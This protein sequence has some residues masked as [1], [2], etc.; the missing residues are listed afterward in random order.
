MIR[1]KKTQEKILKEINS[2]LARVDKCDEMSYP[3]ISPY[4]GEITQENLVKYS[5]IIQEWET[6]VKKLDTELINL[7]TPLPEESDKWFW[8]E[9]ENLKRTYWLYELKLKAEK[10]LRF[11]KYG[12]MAILTYNKRRITIN[13]RQDPTSATRYWVGKKYQGKDIGIDISEAYGCLMFSILPHQYNYQPFGGINSSRMTMKTAIKWADEK[14]LWKSKYEK[15]VWLI[16]YA[17]HIGWDKLRD[18]RLWLI[19]RWDVHKMNKNISSYL[20]CK[21]FDI[22]HFEECAESEGLDHYH[23]E[24]RNPLDF[25]DPMG[26]LADYE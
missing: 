8:L 10:R 18:L 2:Y 16:N 23:G 17:R 24:M 22:R 6:E 3:F 15:I 26:C 13:Q 21:G 1:Y 11:A 20:H 19:W 7:T 12:S 4:T 25:Q 14:A 5:D 9:T